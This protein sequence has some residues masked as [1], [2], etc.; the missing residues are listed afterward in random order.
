MTTWISKEP[1][2]SAFEQ[3]ESEPVEDVTADTASAFDKFRRRLFIRAFKTFTQKF[4]LIRS[5]F[6]TTL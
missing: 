3:T 4:I 6:A 5:L 2:L 1:F